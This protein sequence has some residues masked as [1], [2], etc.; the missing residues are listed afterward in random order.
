VPLASDQ[1]CFA[2]EEGN[3]KIAGYIGGLAP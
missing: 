1:I 2:K 3:W